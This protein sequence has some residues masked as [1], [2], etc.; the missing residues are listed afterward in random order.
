[1]TRILLTS[2]FL[3]AACN[4]AADLDQP[5]RQPLGKAD[6]VGSCAESDCDGPAPTGT[7]WCDDAC[8]EFGDCCSDRV[9]VCEAPADKLC[10]GFAGLTCGVG[11][12]CDLGAVDGCEVAD[13]AG[14]CR[15][16]PEICTEVFAPVCGCDGQTYANS[17]FAA[18]AGASVLH[19][20]ECGQPE[21]AVCGGFAGLQCDAD[22]FCSYPASEGCGFADGLGT[23][24]PKPEACIQVFDPVCG[25]DGQT[26]SNACMANAAGVSVVSTGA[27]N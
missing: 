23:C 21:P 2:V 10:G 9:E 12:Y 11:E 22:E 19:E 6:N 13:G 25:C 24:A 17:C 7:C 8:V 1:M 27:C 3:F 14:V 26:Y 18:G 20:G 16:M 15:T 5:D 4:T